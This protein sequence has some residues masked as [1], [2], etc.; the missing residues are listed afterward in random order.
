[1]A[2]IDFTPSFTTPVDFTGRIAQGTKIIDV[3]EILNQMIDED[4]QYFLD[5]FEINFTNLVTPISD[6]FDNLIAQNNEDLKNEVL[7]Q[8]ITLN[9][10]NTYDITVTNSANALHANDAD[11]LTGKTVTEI[12]DQIRSEIPSY[13]VTNAEHLENKTL[14]EILALVPDIFVYHARNADLLNS[15]TVDEI[16][17]EIKD[18]I[19]NGSTSGIDASTLSGKTLTEILD[20]IQT[21]IESSS[22]GWTAYRAAT[23]G[24]ETPLEWEAK[25]SEGVVANAA[26]ADKLQDKT[27]AEINDMWASDIQIATDN[28]LTNYDTSIT[29]KIKT[30]IVDNA[31]DA[32]SF[33]GDDRTTWINTI[34]TTTVDNATNSYLFDGDDRNAWITTIK[35]TIMNYTDFMAVIENKVSNEWTAFV[36]QTSISADVA[37]ALDSAYKASLIE[38][39]SIYVGAK[40]AYIDALKLEG[41]SVQDIIDLVSVSASADIIARGAGS[42]QASGSPINDDLLI[43]SEIHKYQTE[44]TLN[45][46]IKSF[47]E[48]VMGSYGKTD[49]DRKLTSS[50]D[51]D[52]INLWSKVDIEYNASGQPIKKSFYALFDE[53]NTILYGYAFEEYT[54]GYSAKLSGTDVPFTIGYNPD[55]T[56]FITGSGQPEN[57]TIDIVFRD[58]STGTAIVSADGTW[59]SN[60]TTPQI[61]FRNRQDIPYAPL[62]LKIIDVEYEYNNDLLSKKQIK[63]GF[64]GTLLFDI[65]YSYVWDTSPF[66]TETILS[67]DVIGNQSS[68]SGASTEYFE[69]YNEPI[70][71][72]TT[73][74]VTNSIIYE[75]SNPDS[76]ININPNDK[77]YF[78]KSYSFVNWAVDDVVT[79]NYSIENLGSDLIDVSI[80]ESNPDISITGNIANL[81]SGATDSSTIIGTYTLTATDIK[82]GRLPET[83]T[84]V[85]ATNSVGDDIL[86]ESHEKIEKSTITI[87][88]EW[89]KLNNNV[90]YITTTTY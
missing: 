90:G 3:P 48:I 51:P 67:V 29:N 57:S 9:P 19:L 6:Y 59:S 26:N 11:T 13:T 15:K 78:E 43:I 34:K 7:G 17:T 16:K 71:K 27:L 86:L 61:R 80:F 14:T 62:E 2:I 89:F 36:A 39:T 18:E 88:E 74:T 44:E 69:M 35:N 41:K 28:Y 54:S 12:W 52:A 75:Q 49:G 85:S 24:G 45:L 25:I 79:I 63:D 8:V 66:R 21:N 5:N 82:T 65:N 76:I 1:M 64:D 31:L 55:N 10:D 50:F 46:L 60:S 72:I 83:A 47:A 68:V 56:V 38:E 32:S 40:P 4:R 53:N 84:T 81:A 22:G 58:G 30:T 87:V 20:S 73:T 33:D 42:L 77:V 23:F 37:N 70:K